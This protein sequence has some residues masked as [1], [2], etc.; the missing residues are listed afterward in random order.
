MHLMRIPLSTG[1]WLISLAAATAP[2]TTWPAISLK[3]P[4]CSERALGSAF[5]M[6][7]SR[8]RRSVSEREPESNG[9]G[10]ETI[11]T[12]SDSARARVVVRLRIGE[13]M[14]SRT[15]YYLVGPGSGAV[16]LEDVYYD[17]PLD[18]ANAKA[19]SRYRTIH[20]FCNGTPFRRDS[21][22]AAGGLLRDLDK[23]VPGWRT[24]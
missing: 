12:Y 16:E 11:L 8:L 4:D 3:A 18:R 22:N 24:R 5:V 9:S 2:T 10:G 1:I 14:L 7:T 21:A 13:I 23:L 15:A 19:V 20:Y 6:D 17:M